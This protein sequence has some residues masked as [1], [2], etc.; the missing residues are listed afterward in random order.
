PDIALFACSF[1]TKLPGASKAAPWHEDATY[2]GG[3]ADR[4]EGCTD[5]GRIDDL[6][7]LAVRNPEF[8]DL[9]TRP[10]CHGYQTFPDGTVAPKDHHYALKINRDGDIYITTIYPFALLRV[11]LETLSR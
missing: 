11:T 9:R 2:W 8:V 5:R 3:L 6:D 4:I 1:I 7:I 10:H